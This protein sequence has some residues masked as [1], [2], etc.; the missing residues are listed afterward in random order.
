MHVCVISAAS[1]SCRVVDSPEAPPANSFLVKVLPYLMIHKRVKQQWK[2]AHG[3]EIS[4]DNSSSDSH[5]QN[6][7]PCNLWRIQ[8]WS[9]MGKTSRWDGDCIRWLEIVF[10]S[11]GKATKGWKPKSNSPPEV[12]G[13]LW[14]MLVTY[15]VCHRCKWWKTMPSS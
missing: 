5:C 14:D 6:T 10:L 15:T 1:M 11:A 13:Y 7:W 2:P 9:C 3:V 12:L 4:L 8:C